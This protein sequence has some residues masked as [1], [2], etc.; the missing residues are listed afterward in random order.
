MKRFVR[1]RLDVVNHW[2]VEYR[3]GGQW[4]VCEIMVGKALPKHFMVHRFRTRAT[5]MAFAE[6]STPDRM[7]RALTDA[8]Y[9]EV[10]P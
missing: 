9:A 10:T 5:A 6:A 3:G 1:P 2:K 8:L 7:Q 4:T